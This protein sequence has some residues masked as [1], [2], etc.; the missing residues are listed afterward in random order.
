MSDFCPQHG[1]I[2]CRECE[3][4]TNDIGYPDYDQEDKYFLL[5]VLSPPSDKFYQH[6]YLLVQEENPKIYEIIKSNGDY[7]NEDQRKII[8]EFIDGKHGVKTVKRLEVGC[9]DTKIITL[10]K[11]ILKVITVF[12]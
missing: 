7:L 2:A 6:E 8:Q 3:H 4:F 12:M 5:I 11:H 10:N 1:N 9:N